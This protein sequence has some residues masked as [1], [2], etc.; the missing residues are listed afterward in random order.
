M[1]GLPNLQ[2]V[3]GGLSQTGSQLRSDVG[4]AAEV[5]HVEDFGEVLSVGLELG[6]E[7]F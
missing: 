7:M 4:E 5:D 2:I 3:A 6:G 1:A